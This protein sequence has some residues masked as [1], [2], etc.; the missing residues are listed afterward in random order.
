VVRRRVGAALAAIVGVLFE[1][2]A[3]GQA[4]ASQAAIDAIKAEG[5]SRSE[6]ARLF[7]LLTDSIG[8]RLSGS[9]GHVAAA[10]WAVDQLKGWGLVDAHLDPFEFGRGWTLEKLTVEMA[11]PRY[12]PLLAYAEAWSPA[13]KGLVSGH[14]VYVGGLSLDDLNRLGARL[15]GAIVLGYKPQTEFLRVDR[16][17]PSTG[18]PVT[19]GNP[20]YPDASSTI[21]PA[22]LVERLRALGAAAVLRPGAMEHGTVRVQGNR[23]TARD[24]VPTVVIAAEQ[25]NMLVRMAQARMQL[26]LRVEV[27]ARFEPGPESY[28]VIA[29]IP[30]SDPVLRDEVVMVGAHLDS[31]HTAT[32]A[33]D[34]ADGVAATMEAMRIL[35]RLGTRPRRTVRI[36]LWSGEE[37]GLLG[38]N[39]YV[40]KYLS[41]EATRGRISVYLNDDPGTGPTYGFY[42]QGNETAKRLFDS[43]LEPLRDLGVRRNVIEG[44]NATDHLAFDAAGIP[45]FTIIKNFHNYDTRTRHTNVDFADAVQDD[46]LRQSA[47]VLAA[48]IW[49]AASR[50]ER[51][52]RKDPSK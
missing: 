40:A 51:I 38:S 10:R 9:P 34:N 12:M 33:T 21:A 16:M 13:T 15:R 5:M 46:D 44:I 37:Q 48:F 24:A 52:P 18:S 31:W 23:A 42:M 20:P 47:T 1:V 32:G 25:Y 27:G 36:A 8:P 14:P 7:H 26:Q 41:T 39:A 43:W 19:T 17:D 35:S 2:T 11:G 4:P 22:V 50:D 6:A 3:F 30:G 49:Q 45:A 29:D 28:N